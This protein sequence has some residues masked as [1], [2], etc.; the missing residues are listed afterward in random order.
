MPVGKK[1]MLFHNEQ[2]RKTLGVPSEGFSIPNSDV[3]RHRKTTPE[4]WRAM[5]W[6]FYEFPIYIEVNPLCG[7]LFSFYVLNIAYLVAGFKSVGKFATLFFIAWSNRLKIH[8]IKINCQIIINTN[9]DRI[10]K[11]VLSSIFGFKI[12]NGDS[13]LFCIDNPIFPNTS[14]TIF[15]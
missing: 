2:Q 13:V 14:S 15:E 12:V 1:I 9:F 3:E 11:R 10:R 4:L 5:E 6:W 7:R 8:W